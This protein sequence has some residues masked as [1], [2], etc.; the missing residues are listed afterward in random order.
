MDLNL[1]TNTVRKSLILLA[2]AAVIISVLVFYQKKVRYNL[3]TISETKSTI[4]A[5]YHPKNYLSF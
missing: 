2:A 1:K 5:L 4:L 3:V